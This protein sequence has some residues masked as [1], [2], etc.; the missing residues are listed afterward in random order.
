MTI[1]NADI[2]AIPRRNLGCACDHC[3]SIFARHNSVATAQSGF[4]TQ[5]LQ[6]KLHT[7]QMFSQQRKMMSL[8]RHQ[9]LTA[10]VEVL[11]PS[12]HQGTG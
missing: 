6:V 7:G 12:V 4:W 5:S 10:F 3:A 9:R 11:S 8:Q 1:A 2:D